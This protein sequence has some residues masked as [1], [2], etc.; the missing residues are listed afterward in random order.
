M[1]NYLFY[2]NSICLDN[3]TFPIYISNLQSVR[4]ISEICC[5]NLTQVNLKLIELVHFSNN[6]DTLLETH[7]SLAM[8][9]MAATGCDSYPWPMAEQVE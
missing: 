2:S 1:S 5:N 3:K 8:I 4:Y 6:T 9:R 7:V